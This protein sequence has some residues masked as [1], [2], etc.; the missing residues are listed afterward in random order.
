MAELSVRRCSEDKLM[1]SAMVT[2]FQTWS[3]KE[4]RSVIQILRVK[5]VSLIEIHRQ[6]IQARDDN[7][8]KVE[9]VRKWCREFESGL[10]CVILTAL[11]NAAYL[12]WM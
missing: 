8:L 7:V 12:E 10:K 4:I 11:V 9:R 6:L 5:R 2:T 1:C 3:C